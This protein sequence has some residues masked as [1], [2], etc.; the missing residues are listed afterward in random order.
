MTHTIRRAARSLGVL[1]AVVASQWRCTVCGRT[2][3]PNY[4]ICPYCR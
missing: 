4:K 2:I 1:A 3:S